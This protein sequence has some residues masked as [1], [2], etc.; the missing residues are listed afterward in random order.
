VA[1]PIEAEDL[2]RGVDHR[3]AVVVGVVGALEEGDR[4]HHRELLGDAR[5][6]SDGLVPREGPG[7]REEGLLLLPAEVGPLEE[8]GG[9][10]ETGS[11]LVSL[12]HVALDPG[13]VLVAG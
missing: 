2:A 13:D 12:A 9:Q 5:E 11:T 1:L 3:H 8:L 7:P 4:D 6:V 10:D